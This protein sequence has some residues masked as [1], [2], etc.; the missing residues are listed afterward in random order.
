MSD[1]PTHKMRSI[2]PVTRDCRF[3]D[4]EANVREMVVESEVWMERE[5]VVKSV[6]WNERVVALENVV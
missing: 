5:V 4:L 6:V 3:M 1:P 2:Q